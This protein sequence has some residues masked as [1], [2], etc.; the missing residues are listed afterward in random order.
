MDTVKE[1]IDMNA[2][3]AF[4]LRMILT[5]AEATLAAIKHLEP[6]MYKAYTLD[7]DIVEQLKEARKNIGKAQSFTFD[8][9]QSYKYHA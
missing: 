6:E 7:E 5:K 9:F 3:D 1:F 8:T 4:E 2:D